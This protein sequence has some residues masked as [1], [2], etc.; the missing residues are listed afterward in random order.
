MAI[1][2]R[3]TLKPGKEELLAGW[4]GEQRWYAGKGGTP[5]LTLLGG[6]RFDDPAGQV[7]VEVNIVADSA[8]GEPVVY[9]IPMTYRG[10]PLEGGDHAAVLFEV[11]EAHVHHK[12]MKALDHGTAGL[13]YA[14]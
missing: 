10:S 4:I 12:E 5:K 1:L 11:V 7:G 14:G 6:Y 2:H 13:H 3:A 8:T 9:Q